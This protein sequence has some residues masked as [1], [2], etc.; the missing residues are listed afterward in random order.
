MYGRERKK[1]RE[2]GGERERETCSIKLIRIFRVCNSAVFHL[3]SPFLFRVHM[4]LDCIFLVRRPLAL[5]AP[6]YEAKVCLHDGF[7][8]LKRVCEK[9][10]L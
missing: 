8:L 3:F 6:L 9:F 2:R 1:E 4:T 5:L 10:S 7:C